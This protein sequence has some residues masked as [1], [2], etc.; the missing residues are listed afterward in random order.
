M[1][2][3]L[4]W[5]NGAH[6]E[7]CVCPNSLKLVYSCVHANI[8]AFAYLAM[9]AYLC[10]RGYGN[11][12]AKF[13]VVA[14]VTMC[15]KHTIRAYVRGLFAPGIHG[16]QFLQPCA[17]A[18][19]YAAACVFGARYFGGSANN[20]QGANICVCIYAYVGIYYRCWVYVCGWMYHA[21]SS[22]IFWE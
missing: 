3:T 8:C 20:A 12:I 5:N 10:P 22:R 4:L 11:A 2:N 14:Y 13:C 6:T 9:P 16:N 1:G 15:H 21:S 17:F 7:Q 19:E 18:N